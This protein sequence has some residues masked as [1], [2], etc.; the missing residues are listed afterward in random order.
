MPPSVALEEPL[1]LCLRIIELRQ[2]ARTKAAVDA[3]TTDAQM[4]SGP[5]AELVFAVEHE[6]LEARRARM[7]ARERERE[8]GE[9]RVLR[10][11]PD[12]HQGRRPG[13]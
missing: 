3:A 12:R 2:Y 11:P 7:A 4:P 1:L 9:P 8:G 13:Q 5:M 6:L 10:R